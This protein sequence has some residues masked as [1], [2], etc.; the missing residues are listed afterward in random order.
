[1]NEKITKEMARISSLI[2]EEVTEETIKNS[3]SEGLAKLMKEGM[4]KEH[5]ERMIKSARPMGDFAWFQN[6]LPFDEFNK[7]FGGPV[8]KYGLDGSLDHPYGCFGASTTPGILNIS[9]FET[10]VD[11]YESMRGKKKKPDA[12]RD[13]IFY[14]G[15]MIEPVY[16]EYFRHMY[17]HRYIVF[18]C[19]IQ[20]HSRKYPHFIGNCD[21]LLYDK[22]TGELGI[23]EIKH[24]SPNNK[25][26]IRNVQEGDPDKH[27][28]MQERCYMELLDA[29]FAVLFLGWGNR[30]GLDTNAAHRINRESELGEDFLERCEDFMVN[31]V[32]KG[33]K[34]SFRNAKDAT[35]IKDSMNELYGPVVSGAKALKFDEK[36]LPVL[37]ALEKAQKEIE[38]AKQNEKE[39]KEKVEDAEAAYEALQLPLIEALKNSPKGFYVDSDGKHFDVTYD[40][41]KCLDVEKV[42]DNYPD[43]YDDCNKSAVDTKALKRRYPDVYRDCYGPKTGGTRKFELN[44]WSIKH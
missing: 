38:L 37:E 35:R 34:P 29:D 39:A 13:E 36:L 26:T 27:W 7:F 4:P 11:V 9:P 6:R 8:R 16:R 15:H 23:L 2:G 24:T 42:R 22:E 17:G 41:R 44:V 1:M 18:D 25:K 30:P 20:W 3:Y 10:A 5:I 33:I 28:D 32:E 21:G 19:D 40:V 14:A 43:A 12:D 31:N